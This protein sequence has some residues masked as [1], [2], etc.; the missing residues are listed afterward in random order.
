MRAVQFD[1]FGDV[2]VLTVREVDDP[3][4]G[5]G[6]VLVAVEAV[7]INPGQAKRRE[8]H[9]THVVQT[10]FP[11]G[12]GP[13]LAGVVVA[14]GEG[15]TTFAPGDEVLGWSEERTSQAELVAVAADNLT[16]KPAGCARPGSAT[17]RW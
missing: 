9:M 8:G 3:I 6:Q 17:A 11:A 10:T 16:A 13:D 1:E 5:F 15:M 14:V 4:A 2:D 7:G 12:Q